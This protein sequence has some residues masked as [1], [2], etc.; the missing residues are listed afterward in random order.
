[1]L[2]ALAPKFWT[3]NW[4]NKKGAF[5]M[6]RTLKEKLRCVHLHLDEEMTI[7]EIEQ[8]YGLNRSALKYY[9]SCI[10]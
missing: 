8:I 2:N 9:C 7:K 5:N 3:K 1:M 4:Y 6:K 10:E